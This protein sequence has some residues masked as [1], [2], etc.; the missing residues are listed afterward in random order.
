VNRDGPDVDAPSS[1]ARRPTPA[2]YR[3]LLRNR[4]Y[5]RIFAAGLG[6]IAGS[7]IAGVSLVWL[8]AV[9]TGSALDVAA[10]AIASLLA[11]ASFSVFGGTIVDRYD[12]R[13]LMIGS[14]LGRAGALFVAFLVLELAG[15]NLPVIVAVAAAVGAFG[16]VFNPA[17][18]VLVPRLV[19]QDEVGNANG[20]IRSTRGALQFAG[21]G[22]GGVLLFAVGPLWGIAA[23]VVTFLLSAALLSGIRVAP[24]PPAEVRARSAGRRGYFAELAEGFGWLRRAT[25]FL[26]L[27]F[28]ATAF[29]VCSSAVGTFL[30]LYSNDVLHG[31]SL[32]FALL[33]AFEV[34]GASIGA[35]LVGPTGAVRFAGRAWTIPYGIVSGVVALALPL[36]PSV[37]VAFAALFALGALGGYAGTAWLTAAQILV[38]TEMQGRY[39]GIDN[40]GSVISV[41]VGQLAG[42]LLIGAVG[43]RATFLYFAV[44]WIVAGA[45]FLAPRAL[46][47]LGVPE[48]TPADAPPIRSRSDGDAP[49]RRG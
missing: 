4:G 8:V 1:G 40:L 15:F 38:P 48:G 44:A 25:G 13:R 49:G 21:T 17:E 19:A 45:A 36:F 41:P 37:P 18:N 26:Q 42:A 46:W 12:A 14:D 39:F 20:L 31:T 11:S 16:T 30:V 24:L 22:I 6:S 43:L 10:L 28:S 29:N 35:L 33:L 27:T 34:A 3:S 47:R 2:A 9:E 23:N 5:L 7:A 32:T